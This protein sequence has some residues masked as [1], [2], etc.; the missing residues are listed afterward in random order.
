MDLGSAGGDSS[1]IRKA[2]L[3]PSSDDASSLIDSPA[4]TLGVR[5]GSRPSSKSWDSQ[6]ASQPCLVTSRNISISGGFA[7]ANFDSIF[8]PE[9]GGPASL[10]AGALGIAG[11]ARGRKAGRRLPA[12]APVEID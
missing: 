1:S 6:S 2:A 4:R 10:A 8:L 3:S 5:E 12:S 9:P 7:T 11:L